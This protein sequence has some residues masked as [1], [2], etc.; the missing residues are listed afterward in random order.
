MRQEECA[1]QVNGALGKNVGRKCREQA[2]QCQCRKS[3]S[4]LPGWCG[5]EE[6]CPTV[7][8]VSPQYDAPHRL[9]ANLEFIP[10][11]ARLI[12]PDQVVTGT[13]LRQKCSDN[14]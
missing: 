14:R 3:E 2:K 5:V 6:R 12:V 11:R 1:R 9:I 8:E 7:T 4:E 10:P 13:L